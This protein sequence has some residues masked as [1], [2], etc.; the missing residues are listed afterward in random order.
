M[1]LKK[2]LMAVMSIIL[3]SGLVLMGC[4]SDSS[5]SEKRKLSYFQQRVEKI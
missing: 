1:I 3:I 4:G 5:N 2:K